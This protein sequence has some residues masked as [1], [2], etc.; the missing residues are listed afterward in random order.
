M[1]RE[2]SGEFGMAFS[3]LNGGRIAPPLPRNDQGVSGEGLA[4]AAW[5]LRRSDAFGGLLRPAVAVLEPR[6]A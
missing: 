5:P 4:G 2:G 6:V 3:L 1:P